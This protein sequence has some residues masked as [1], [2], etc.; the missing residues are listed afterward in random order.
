MAIL[1]L[2]TF[3]D[4]QDA[5]REELRVPTQDTTTL[6]RIKRDINSVYKDLI[7]RKRWPWLHKFITLTHRK[8][9]ETGTVAVTVS[10]RAATLSSAPAISVKGYWFRVDRNEE[11]YRIEQHTA[12]ATAIVLQSDYTDTTT[13][14]A[15]Y[16][17]WTDRIPLPSDCSET[18]EVTHQWHRYPLSNLGRQEFRIKSSRW[19]T[20]EG[21]PYCYSTNDYLDPD[22]YS[23]ATKTPASR[24]SV[25]LIK[26]IVFGVD[27]SSDLSVGDFIENSG[28][29]DSSYNGQFRVSSVATTT[30]TFT[31]LV[32]LSE[33]NTVDVGGAT[34]KLSQ[35][36]SEET[37]R[38]L[39][40]YPSQFRDRDITLHTDY[41]Q[42]APDL[43]ADADE[44]LMPVNDRSVLR[45]GVLSLQWVKHRNPEASADNERK[46]ETKLRKMEA[47]MG[48]SS[49]KPNLFT[50]PL[51]VSQRKTG[52]HRRRRRY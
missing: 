34:Q 41:I 8:M 2:I 23:I 37:F 50:D 28:Y 52:L 49:D 48:D 18:V 20:V 22:A 21:L 10:S 46:F 17:I 45:Y 27:V 29:G 12:G 26:T 6:N 42:L 44:P 35:R 5:V 30:I 1:T 14:A 7:S 38:E 36:T 25:S 32:R 31:G 33:S 3:K 16:R 40:V 24:S 43:D 4:I 51:W 9:I 11:I 13:A 15:S 19:A 47:K 39:W